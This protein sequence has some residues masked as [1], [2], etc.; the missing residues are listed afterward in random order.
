MSISA[1]C[2]DTWEFPTNIDI[3]QGIIAPIPAVI[4]PRPIA[5]SVRNMAA[6]MLVYSKPNGPNN[7]VNIKLVNLLFFIA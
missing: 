6:P 7:N 3:N 5:I 4:E 2:L 1:L